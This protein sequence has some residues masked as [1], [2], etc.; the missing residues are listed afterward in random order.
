M[1]KILAGAAVAAGLFASMP[2]NAE[3]IN[4]LDTIY[5]DDSDASVWQET[6]GVP[7]LQREAGDDYDADTRAL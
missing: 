6:N 2:A 3:V 1:K 5:V 7:G 4:V